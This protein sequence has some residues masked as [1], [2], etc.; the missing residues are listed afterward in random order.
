MLP[1]ITAVLYYV[2]PAALSCASMYMSHRTH[3]VT[4]ADLLNTQLF[5]LPQCVH[6][7]QHSNSDNHDTQG[8]THLCIEWEAILTNFL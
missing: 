3:L 6:H 7:T 4:M 1:S 5:L 8:V 2:L